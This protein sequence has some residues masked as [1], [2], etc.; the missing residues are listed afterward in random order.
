MLRIS[1]RTIQEL[2]AGRIDLTTFN[3]AHGFDRGNPFLRNLEDGC[4]I[5]S[6]EIQKPRN[7]QDDDWIVFTFGGP[8]PAVSPFRTPG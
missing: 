3:Q 1:L 7:Q 2:L 4:L 6:I 5:T 8:D